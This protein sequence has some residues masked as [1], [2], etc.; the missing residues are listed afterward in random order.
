MSTG[1]T[2]TTSTMAAHSVTSISKSTIRCTSE[3]ALSKLDSP[4][5][6]GPLDQLVPPIIPVAVV[7][8]YRATE[9]GKEAIP[10]ERLKR[11]ISTLLDYHPHLSGR[12][13]INESD[14]VR[15]INRLNT[16]MG[17]YEAQCA[18]QLETISPTPGRILLSDLPEG[19]N[20]L[21]APIEPTFDAVCR[22]P[23]FTIQHTRFACGGVA[24]GVRTLHTVIDAEGFFQVVR[25]LAEI[26]RTD[27]LARPPHLRP[28]LAELLHNMTPED[29]ESALQF[30]PPLHTLTTD[31]AV[32]EPAQN[33]AAPASPPPPVIG[34]V[35]R[36]S[37]ADLSALKAHATNPDDS[38][39]WVS[40]FDA[41]SAHIWQRTYAARVR[42]VAAPATLSRSFLTSVN[43]RA[44]LSVP[45]RSPFNCLVTPYGALAHDELA[46]A[47]LHRV[48]VAV[49]ALVRAVAPADAAATARWVAAQP[50]VRRVAWGFDARAGSTMV[51][52]W[53]KFDVYGGAAF[54]GGRPPALVAPP[55]TS[56]SLVDGLGYPMPTEG[57]ASGGAEI[58]LYLALSEAVWE[59]LDGDEEWT[60]FGSG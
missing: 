4:M 20:A 24:L 33:P 10:L 3:A 13:H 52:A 48:A 25:D 22:D 16:G 5:I 17:L 31:E 40:T 57:Q 23:I 11:A 2:T 30:K 35:I 27:T 39:T 45:A 15:G 60:R 9:D 32:P 26:Y 43:Y 34:R 50:D 36:Y 49:H 28:Y 55:F 44:H 8:V 59:V 14:G 37:S 6:L 58:D 29:R 54:E 12:L 42:L 56:V 18:S 19:G 53:N 38:S 51:S 46:G 1:N 41:L 47:P 7:Y 21:L